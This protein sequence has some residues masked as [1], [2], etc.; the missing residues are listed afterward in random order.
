MIT[1]PGQGTAIPDVDVNLL[2]GAAN[3]RQAARDMMDTGNGNDIKN[4]LAIKHRLLCGS[5]L[6]VPGPSSVCERSCDRNRRA[7]EAATEAATDSAFACDRGA[8]AIKALTAGGRSSGTSGA[9]SSASRAR[10]S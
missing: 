10:R 3:A 7:T 1:I 5:G 4:F 9:A 8:G 6:G 2:T